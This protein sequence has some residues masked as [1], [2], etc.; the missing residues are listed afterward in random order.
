M[1]NYWCRANE[2]RKIKDLFEKVSNRD[3][4]NKEKDKEKLDKI[5]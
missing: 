5:L 3:N 2:M 4:P 1:T